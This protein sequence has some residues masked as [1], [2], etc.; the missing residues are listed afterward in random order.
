MQSKLPR[1]TDENLI[2]VA[3]YYQFHRELNVALKLHLENISLRRKIKYYEDSESENGD[4]ISLYTVAE[5]TAVENE[6]RDAVDGRDNDIKL[7]EDGK[8]VED[9]QSAKSMSEKIKDGKAFLT[10]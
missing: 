10:G 6:F 7:V 9:N 5:S 8:M 2:E 3:R 4:A 1:I